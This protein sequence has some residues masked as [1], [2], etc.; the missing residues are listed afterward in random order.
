VEAKKADHI[1]IE[2]SIAV[3]RGWKRKI[4]V[5]NCEREDNGQGNTARRGKVVLMSYKHMG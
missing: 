4:V 2:S 3:T 5:K 1:E